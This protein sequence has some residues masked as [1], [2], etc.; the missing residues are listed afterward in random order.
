MSVASGIYTVGPGRDYA[1]WNAAAVD[2]ASTL[3]GDIYFL[4]LD[5]FTQYS[6]GIFSTDLNGH[7]LV[8]SCP[9]PHRG[10]PRSALKTEFQAYGDC[11]RLDVTDSGTDGA[12]HVSNLFLERTQADSSA[13]ALVRVG[14][15]GSSPARIFIHDL[16]VHGNS[17]STGGVRVNTIRKCYVW[18]I[19]GGGCSDG[20]LIEVI[21]DSTYAD[22][23]RVENCTAYA[24]Y[25]GF[26][27]LPSASV[28][29]FLNCVSLDHTGGGDF[30][31]DAAQV[32]SGNI[33]KDDTAGDF[34]GEN[35]LHSYDGAVNSPDLYNE[36]QGYS[37]TSTLLR[38]KDDA[39]VVPFGGVASEIDDSA[40]AVRL[41]PR[42]NNTG[43]E[44]NLRPGADGE[45]SRGADEQRPL[46]PNAWTRRARFQ[47]NPDYYDG[48]WDLPLLVRK[49]AP[50]M[51]A[52]FLETARAYGEDVRV[53]IDPEGQEPVDVEVFRFGPDD[54]DF[55]IWAKPDFDH[56]PDKVL[57]FYVWWGCPSASQL[58]HKWA[59]TPDGGYGV[60]VG[61]A[62]V[63]H[64][65]NEFDSLK[66]TFDSSGFFRHPVMELTG[67]GG[68]FNNYGVGEGVW[69]GKANDDR[70]SIPRL[71]EP[72]FSQPLRNVS[73]IQAFASLRCTTQPH[74]DSLIE[75]RS[76]AGRRFNLLFERLSVP[77]R[78]PKVEVRAPDS[79]SAAT[80]DGVTDLTTT[81]HRVTVAADI[82]SDRIYIYVDGA[83]D[84]DQAVSLANTLTDDTDLTSLT[85]GR[86]VGGLYGFAGVIGEL[87]LMNTNRPEEWWKA[88][89]ENLYSSGEFYDGYLGG[90][91]M[92][93]VRSVSFEAL[94]SGKFQLDNTDFWLSYDNDG[95][96]GLSLMLNG[97]WDKVCPADDIGLAR[98]VKLERMVKDLSQYYVGHKGKLI[99][100]AGLD[101]EIELNDVSLM[102]ADWEA[103]DNNAGLVYSLEFG[104]N[105]GIAGTQT[106]RLLVFGSEALAADNLI[107]EY[108]GRDQTQFK[109]VFRAAPVRIPGGPPIKRLVV[110]A[111]VQ[112]LGPGGVAERRRQA[113]EIIKDWVDNH[114]GQ[115]R[116]LTIDGTGY[117]TA[118]LSAVRPGALDLPEAVGYSLEFAIEYGS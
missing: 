59:G 92:N 68:W 11:I 64:M 32:G 46:F 108:T 93:G 48:D 49:D 63:L 111:I 26:R 35:N 25:Y 114:L 82:D 67:G 75:A 91:C 6:E 30:S 1:D 96:G 118:H 24:S 100:D 22:D 42:V 70:M 103:I 52:D 8:I 97:V 101:S 17:L 102:V 117:G 55:T 77:P 62:V 28:G 54:E 112:T 104:L 50:G 57:A 85:I 61:Y 73:G 88:V 10:H 65:G 9:F 16:I 12:A 21:D 116:V 45:Y 72:A 79:G 31:V 80:A 29:K 47:L 81:D 2:L 60:W 90:A 4:Q 66:F 34:V 87:R 107:V 33:S 5:P 39:E 94:G 95:A 110:S 113:E 19:K 14:G 40:N 38:I 89:H 74:T 69:W 99:I 44:L 105:I 98:R 43:A 53:T 15:T 36:F 56:E 58:P 109:S 84:K 51:P 18:N 106:A 20:A 3:T 27:V 13:A 86:E 115:E 71:D 78:I 7:N 37:Y 76:A 83:L 41:A 23:L